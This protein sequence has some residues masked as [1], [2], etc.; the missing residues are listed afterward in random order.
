MN[1][2]G[3]KL[4]LMLLKIK[5]EDFWK[6]TVDSVKKNLRWLPISGLY[7]D[8]MKDPVSSNKCSWY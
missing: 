7:G 4:D 6:Q 1:A 8:G 2:I 3:I 5:L